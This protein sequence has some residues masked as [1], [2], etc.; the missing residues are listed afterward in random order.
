LP[1]RA[2]QKRFN[3]G[4]EILHR[5]N[6][7]GRQAPAAVFLSAPQKKWGGAPEGEAARRGESYIFIQKAGF[8]FP[9]A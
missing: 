5:K 2:G 1:D 7:G 4:W 6:G 9:K 3:G 8:L